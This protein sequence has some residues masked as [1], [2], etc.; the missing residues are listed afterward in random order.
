[1][2]DVLL[3]AEIVKGECII[4]DDELLPPDQR[5]DGV[6]TEPIPGYILMIQ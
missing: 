2:E 5:R 6:N 3:S 1:M 4:K